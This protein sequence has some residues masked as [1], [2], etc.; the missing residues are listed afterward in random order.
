MLAKVG[1]RSDRLPT[2]STLRSSRRAGAQAVSWG[3]DRT[4]GRGVQRPP[5][6]AACGSSSY[7]CPSDPGQD[8][9]A[10]PDESLLADFL[11]PLG[12]DLEH[13]R[14]PVGPGL[15]AAGPGQRR[16]RRLHR[17]SGRGRDRRVERHDL[18][19][20]DVPI[21]ARP[22]PPV[23]PVVAPGLLPAS[24]TRTTRAALTFRPQGFAFEV[25]RINANMK[26]GD[27]PGGAGLGGTGGTP[28][29]N[30]LPAG[31]AWPDTSDSQ[32]AGL[33]ST[34]GIGNDGQWRLP[35][36]PDPGGA[37]FLFGDGSVKF[38]KESIDMAAYQS[39]GTRQWLA[40]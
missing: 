7:V 32:G 1:A 20:R 31:T 25:P 38:L 29:P 2:R 17:V 5:W 35:E 33:T 30:A 16:F 10:D 28:G 24:R 11:R 23:Q 34:R 37:N 36:P 4:L 3:A 19:R 26:P 12:G 22:R 14:L 13:R 9:N 18:R 6:L 40:N 21:Q 15:L 8:P 27:Y 39:L